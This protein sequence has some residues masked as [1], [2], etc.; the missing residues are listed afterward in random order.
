[1]ATNTIELR[2]ETLGAPEAVRAVQSVR[3]AIGDLSGTSTATRGE[4]GAVFSGADIAKAEGFESHIHDSAAALR[5]LSEESNRTRE[6]LGGV[7][8]RQAITR[9]KELEGRLDQ[10]AGGM[11]RV[12]QRMQDV[13]QGLSLGVTAPLV[14][15]GGAAIKLAMDAAES[16]NLFS[17]SMGKQADAARAWSEE[18]REELGLN[19]YAVRESVAT[20]NVMFGSMSIGEQK[21]YA[22]STSLTELAADMSSFYNISIDEALQKLQAGITGETEPLKRL[23]ILLGENTIQQWAYREGIVETGAALTEQQK[24]LARYGALMEQTSKAQGDLARTIESPTNQLRRLSE[25]ATQAGIELGNNLLPAFS[26]A[27]ESAIPLVETIGEAAEAFAELPKGIQTTAIALT[28]LGAAAGPTV[29]GVGLMVRGIGGIA[30]V[31]KA[32]VSGLIALRSAQ[33]MGGVATVSS[34]ATAGIAGTTASVAGLGT[35]LAVG[36]PV[37]IGLGLLAAAFVASRN[38]AREAAEAVA[39]YRGVIAGLSPAE[40]GFS[41]DQIETRLTLLRHQLA[42]LQEREPLAGSSKEGTA[43]ARREWR[44]QV[45]EVE[46]AIAVADRR[47][48]SV[49]DLIQQQEESARAQKQIADSIK[50]AF[51][52]AMGD[53]GGDGSASPLAAI[54]SEGSWLISL[55]SEAAARGE[56]LTGVL[57]RIAELH[58]E[59]T[60]EIRAQGNA[61]TQERAAL[62]TTESGLIDGLFRGIAMPDAGVVGGRSVT[63]PKGSGLRLETVDPAQIV[64]MYAASAE[65]AELGADA[66]NQ[67]ASIT[68]AS[69]GAMAQAAVAGSAQMEQVVVSSLANIAAA[70]VSKT[71]PV[72]GVAITAVGGVLGALFGRDRRETQPVRVE[73]YSPRALQ[74]QKREGPDAVIVQVLDADTGEMIDQHTYQATRNTRRD[75][76]LRIPARP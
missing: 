69:F 29:L 24:V 39:Q 26:A 58:R 30:T 2:I 12:G 4:V 14:A 64:A 57:G 18:L 1:M 28:V 53:I 36:A 9:L 44:K 37:L 5:D 70:A 32:A 66:F 54:Q 13:G 8:P 15:V 71:N 38:D 17:V 65:G 52:D 19:A 21:A 51:D 61:V 20:F 74:Q 33:A 56:D 25:E 62:L 50:A 45:G 34:A 73:E 16:E 27:V 76:V 47:L 60:A 10:V 46:T 6:D 63:A 72:L 40:L 67:A 7:V 75:R 35:A 41:E 23:G 55:Y 49:Q 11:G 59:I 68:V 31:S 48:T 43:G 3:V 22:M 42:G